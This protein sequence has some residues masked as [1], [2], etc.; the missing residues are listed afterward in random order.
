MAR[1]I[2]LGN[3]SLLVAFDHAYAIRDLHY[4]NLGLEN[5]LMGRRCRLGIHADGAFSWV[6]TEGWEVRLGYE[7]DAL[8]SDA[9][10]AHPDS[11][12]ELSCSDAVDPER[13]I[14]ARRVEVKNLRPEARKVRLFF[15][16]DF[17]I[18]ETDAGDTAHYDPRLRGLIHY[19]RRR[20]LLLNAMVRGVHGL[21]DYS[22]GTKRNRDGRGSA[23]QAE[24]GGVLDQNPIAHGAVDSIF[25]VSL[26]LEPSGSADF[27]VWI[28]AG[29]R[30]QDVAA[31]QFFVLAA[32]PSAVLERARAASR[33]AASTA[34][35]A[36]SPATVAL[37]RRSLLVIETQCDQGGGIVAANDTDIMRF[38]RDTYS[39]VWPRD[40]A[41]VARALDLAGRHE[42]AR[43]F[44]A[45]CVE[46]VAAG[47]YF[48]Q[49]YNTDGSLAS[50]WHPWVRDGQEQLPIQEDE[51]ALVLWALAEQL[52]ESP[53]AD[54]LA[55]SWPRLVRRAADFLYEFR[56]PETGLP[57]PS[58]DLWEERFG[59][60]A[61]TVASVHAALSGAARLADAVGES[62]PASRY[63]TA[64]AEILAAFQRLL[65]HEDLGRYVR[66][67]TRD[68]GGYWHDVTVDA[69]LCGLFL[70]DFLPLED[71]KLVRTIEAVEE[72][73]WVRTD[74]GGIARYENDYYHQV[75]KDVE[76]IP[77]NPWFVCTLWLAEWHARRATDAAGLQQAVK[78]LDWA[79]AHA[80]PSGVMAEQVHPETGEPLSVAPLT[81][82][83]AAYVSAAISI[84]RTQARLR[85]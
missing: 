76:R 74:V 40:G 53:D 72:R 65:Y 71:E 32:K 29:T 83:H 51:T 70:F 34:L 2:P 30:Y 41:L 44:L 3:G 22:T 24:D 63:R 13:P 31:E 36:D 54:F 8:V 64:A 47:G 56:D 16:H 49:K 80:R 58:W 62:A 78:Y 68:K 26:D 5:H 43:R 33:E 38:A 61:F 46:H 81:W 60:H 20:Y 25:A 19:K 52:R 7:P 4:P 11:G 10:L 18:M 37:I 27:W 42:P 82:S 66:M 59:V 50:S 48:F 79:A 73:L 57:L 39:Y 6:G 75:S 9:R 85:V 1:D 12:L 14:L 67:G 23:G 28:I 55:R 21:G 15:H 77:G 45:F 35:A 84:S 69:A 17:D